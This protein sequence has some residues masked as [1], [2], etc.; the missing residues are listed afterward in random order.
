MLRSRI[1]G[2]KL[3]DKDRLNKLK[4]AAVR[5]HKLKGIP[6]NSDIANYAYRAGIATYATTAGIATYATNAGISTYAS[7]AG[8]ATYAI[9]AGIATYAQRAGI[10]TYANTSGIATVAGI[11]TYATIAGIATYA[12]NSGVSTSVIG[13]VASVTQLNVSGISTLGVITAGS[14]FFTGIVTALSFSGDGSQL[15]G[16]IA[17]ASQQWVTTPVGIHTLVNVGVGTTNPTSK[18]TVDGNLYVTGI[19]TSTDYDSLSDRNLK[20]NIQSIQNPIESV[21]Q[22]RGVTFDW[23]ETGRSSAGVVAQEIEKVLPNLVNG[24][25][26]KT[27]NYNGL[28]G[29]LIECV[30]EQQKEIEELKKRLL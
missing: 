23:K 26:V 5:K 20:S 18:L 14:A 9:T 11:S 1:A 15:T 28:I 2:G 8:I 13:G 7:T 4:L 10:A 3:T 22:I 19:I 27:V 16:V 25:D 29:L 30:K 12:P 21:K 24:D 6:T 17:Q